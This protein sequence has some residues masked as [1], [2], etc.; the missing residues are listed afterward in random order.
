MVTLMSPNKNPTIK[1][2]LAKEGIELIKMGSSQEE[3][4]KFIA[5]D[6]NKGIKINVLATC[7]INE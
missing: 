2:Q 5:E 4:E 3:Y 1:I 7:E 6:M